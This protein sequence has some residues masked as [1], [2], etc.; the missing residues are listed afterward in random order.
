M[1]IRVLAPL[2]SLFLCGQLA[3]AQRFHF[4][5][6]SC[7]HNTGHMYVAFGRSVF[8]TPAQANAVVDPLQPNAPHLKAPDPAEPAGCFGN[9]LQSDSY[10]LLGS[11]TLTGSAP[12]NAKLGV[13][14]GLELI[15]LQMFKDWQGSGG[16][17]I[18]EQNERKIANKTC[19]IAAVQEDLSNGFHACRIKLIKPANAPEVDWAASYIAKK[20][21][22]TTPLGRPFVINCGPLMFSNALDYCDA[23]YELTSDLGVYY[24]FR[25]YH[26]AHPISI[27]QIIAFDKFLRA[28][29]EA[30]LVKDYPWPK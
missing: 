4:D 29:V 30:A 24:E 20:N 1:M 14:D 23:E 7:K 12:G 6:S 8:V 22:Y 27:D 2:V 9:P 13:P 17:W 25:P 19:R 11:A 21:I 16:E 10:H 26:T 3:W 18:L 28:A 5:P 15:N